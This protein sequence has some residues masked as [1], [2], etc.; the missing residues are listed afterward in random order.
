MLPVLYP[1][2][3]NIINM[4]I[5]DVQ[6]YKQMISCNPPWYGLGQMARNLVFY[7]KLIILYKS[8]CI[9]NRCLDLLIAPWL[10]ISN[11]IGLD[12]M[13]TWPQAV[14]ITS[15]MVSPFCLWILRKHVS[16]LFHWS[17]FHWSIFHKAVLIDTMPT[18]IN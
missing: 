5:S 2:N 11:Q 14:L 8:A 1:A 18:R 15:F 4:K 12:W 13:P 17:I 10:I 6:I 16:S 9:C 3:I 7:D